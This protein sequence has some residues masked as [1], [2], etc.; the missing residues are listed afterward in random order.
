M[1]FRKNAQYELTP[2]ERQL[3]HTLVSRNLVSAQAINAAKM[4]SSITN[5]SI[6]TILVNNGFL[7]Q[8]DLV[9][10]LLSITPDALMDEELIVPQVPFEL[11]IKHKIMLA[12][13]T[14][15]SVFVACLCPTAQARNLLARYFPKQQ[16]VFI[17]ANVERIH[18][19]V[20]KLRIISDSDSSILE[21]LLREAILHKASDIHIDPRRNSYS[22][23]MRF[24]GVRTHVHEGD[25]DEYLVLAAKIKD[26]SKMDLAER[27]VPQD[28]GF[29]IEYNGRLIDLRVAAV[30]TNFGESI[31]I[32][33]LD[34][35]RAQ[36]NLDT[37]GISGINDWKKGIS[38]SDGLCLICGP[39]G[40]GKTT[41]LNAT[42]RHLDR[43]SQAIYTAEDPVEYTTPFVKQVNINETVGLNFTRALRSFM[44]ADPDVI[45][46]GEVRDTDT[47]R[48]AI[49]AAET[50]HLVFATL[51]TGSIHASIQRLK[52][53]DIDPHELKYV[54]RS[55]MVQRLM[56]TLCPVCQGEP[57]HSENCPACGGRRYG[58]RTIVSECSYFGGMQE[59]NRLLTQQDVTWMTM[60]EDAYNKYMAGMTDKLE[61]VRVFGAEAQQIIDERGD[62]P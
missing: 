46:V 32:R 20:E 21:L 52:D 23:F 1:I 33:I 45:I 48:I 60:I 24:L 42:T 35:E 10:T 41:T 37:L 30:P 9:Q 56:R 15:E 4:E 50:G 53:L 14:I 16:L 59:V 31:I 39:T 5:E 49:K 25:L 7:R 3:E 22:V 26:R 58:N 18:S 11:L 57:G 36:F 17:P 43:F 44:R 6:G 40:S 27:R 12:A 38:R 19:Y 2:K 55:V 13:E 8:S 51:H 34:P 62:R 29:S 61:F 54:L 28:G 47:A